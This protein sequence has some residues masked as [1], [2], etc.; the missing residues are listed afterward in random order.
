[1][2]SRKDFLKVQKILEANNS[3]Y[4][5]Y[6]LT[7]KRPLSG[8]VKCSEC[9]DK[10]TGYIAKGK[11]LHYFKCQNKCKGAS[12][13]ALSTP[14]SLKKGIN[15]VF[16]DILSF[17]ELDNSLKDIFRQQL[18]LTIEEHKEEVNDEN[19]KIQKLIKELETKLEALERK[20]IF[21]NL[22]KAVYAK[23]KDELE[24]QLKEKMNYLDKIAVKTSNQE[25]SIE[26]CIEVSKNITKYWGGEDV[27]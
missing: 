4:K 2:V 11:N 19:K 13:N 7:P 21:D 20:Y 27:S 25:K 6:K 23:F 24:L 22:D 10:L 18:I 8:F 3:G 9:G 1:M 26:E 15:D 16:R 12:F 5:K 17:L 14:R